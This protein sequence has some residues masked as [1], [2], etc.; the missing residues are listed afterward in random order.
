MIA[1][2]LLEDIGKAYFNAFQEKNITI[3]SSLLDEN[4][5]LTD[6]FVKTING[7]V[8]VLNANADTFKNVSTIIITKCDLFVD[9]LSC[10]IIGELRISLDKTQLEVVDIIKVNNDNL[11]TSITAYINPIKA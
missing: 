3:L 9:E 2:N 11:I 10:T 6:P 1:R 8:A 7:K 4:V 5:Q